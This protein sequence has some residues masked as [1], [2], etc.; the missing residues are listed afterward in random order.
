MIGAMCLILAMLAFGPRF[1]LFMTWAFTSR[2]GDA[3][4]GWLLPFLGFLLAPWTTL[5]YALL[6]SSGGLSGF[7]WFLVALAAA[8]DLSSYTYSART[9][10][11]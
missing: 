8:A 6:Y 5:V 9:Q 10:F 3:Y 11:R 2:I 1:V 4:D 7:D